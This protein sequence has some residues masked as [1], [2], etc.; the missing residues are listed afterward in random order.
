MRKA[1]RSCTK[2]PGCP[3]IVRAGS[4]DKCGRSS[5]HTPAR[6]DYDQQRGSAAARG[7]G[8]T[9]QRLRLMVLLEEP[10]CR[11]CQ[12]RGETVAATDVDHIIPKREGGKDERS[13]LQA[14]C[15]TCH[16]RK[17]LAGG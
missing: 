16:S 1:G 9:W 12:T 11:E 17:T 2:T 7:Y 13:N 10:L 3:G 5:T 6:K 14:L 15:H 4:C 8:R